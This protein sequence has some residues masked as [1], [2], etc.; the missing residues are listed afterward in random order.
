VTRSQTIRAGL[1]PVWRTKDRNWSRIRPA[2]EEILRE[3]EFRLT[4]N[5]AE[6]SVTCEPDTLLLDVLRHDLGLAGPKFGCG[7][8]L[9]GA[10]FVRPGQVRR[11]DCRQY[12]LDHGSSI[13]R[14]AR[15][16]FK[17]WLRAQG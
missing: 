5:C 15:A 12:T 10:C 6:R 1:R 17:S 3:T 16:C 11:K 8:G 14:G 2:N 7:M 4:V 9:C 13:Y